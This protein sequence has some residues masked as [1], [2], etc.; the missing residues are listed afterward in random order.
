MFAYSAQIS[1]S[2]Q[3]KVHACF[4]RV[5]EETIDGAAGGFLMI[6]FDAAC[7]SVE[8]HVMQNDLFDAF[9]F[10]VAEIECARTR[11]CDLCALEIMFIEVG[12]SR[13]IYGLRGWFLDIVL[14]RG[15]K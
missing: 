8:A 11:G 13:F 14:Q 3:D 1:Q 12:I 7:E 6:V 5:T 2:E 9:H 10:V 15:E 4:A